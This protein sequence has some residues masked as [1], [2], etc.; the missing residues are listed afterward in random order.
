MSLRTIA[1]LTCLVAGAPSAAALQ[2]DAAKSPLR[3]LLVTHDPASPKV[4][5]P[6]MATE[7]TYELYRER[8]EAFATLLREHFADVQVVIGEDYSVDLSDA[9]DVTVFDARPGDDLER[10]FSRPA[11]MIGETSPRIGEPLGLKLDWL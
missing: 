8:G 5:F 3:V 9:V 7:R 6:D 10:S 2:D 1:L 11:L 4:S